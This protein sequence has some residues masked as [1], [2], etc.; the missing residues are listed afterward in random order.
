V[1]GEADLLLLLT[2]VAATD[3]EV[4]EKVVMA[5]VL[6]VDVCFGVV[7]GGVCVHAVV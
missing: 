7:G 6:V 3:G 1:R 5:L 2:S 4:N